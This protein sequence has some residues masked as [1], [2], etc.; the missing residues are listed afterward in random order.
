MIYFA[1]QRKIYPFPIMTKVRVQSKSD[2]CNVDLMVGCLAYFW[3]HY[4]LDRI[5]S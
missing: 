5:D 1:V 2:A 3:T 4:E